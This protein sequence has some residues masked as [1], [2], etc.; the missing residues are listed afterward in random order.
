MAAFQKIL[1]DSTTF[2]PYPKVM[3]RLQPAGK[4]STMGL[5]GLRLHPSPME[6]PHRHNDVELNFI[7]RGAFTYLFGGRRVTVR[8]NHLA[9]FWAAMP[10]QLIAVEPSTGSYWLTLPLGWFLRWR[11][12]DALTQQILRG[13]I[14]AQPAPADA[15][16]QLFEQWVAD[17][18][19]GGPEQRRVVLL[20]LEARLR[21]LALALDTSSPALPDS[22]AAGLSKAERLAQLVVEHFAE[23]WRAADIARAAG[24]H[25][26]YAMTLF[27]DAFGVSIGAYLTQHRVARAQ[28]LLVTTETSVLDIAL[29]SGFGSASRFYAAFK[30]AC[31]LSPHAY[32]ASLH[33]T[34]SNP[35]TL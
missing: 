6:G 10:H 34:H 2:L 30:Q 35:I 12:P 32:R 5:G 26:N 1:L 22:P 11:L 33:L 27:R 19:Q 23:S 9:L 7:E 13:A 14:I 20:E 25:P 8:E 17:L 4:L 24:L 28:Q 3:S 16:Q 18:E 15:D 31:G 21:R 29:Q